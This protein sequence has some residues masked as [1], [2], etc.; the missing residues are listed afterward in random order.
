MARSR[1]VILG[2]ISFLGSA[3]GNRGTAKTP[4]DVACPPGQS[5]DGQYCVVDQKVATVEQPIPAQPTGDEPAETAPETAPSVKP[6]EEDPADLELTESSTS[7][8]Q[9][10]EKQSGEVLPAQGEPTSGDAPVLARKY[11]PATPVDYA[12]AAQA[13]PVMNY[14]ASSHLPAGS[15]PLGAP[16]AGQFAEGEMHWPV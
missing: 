4:A 5:Y 12:M 7:S 13:A 11:P 8:P 2:A 1:W 6:T 3:C 10:G 14:L 9:G 15:K 16:F